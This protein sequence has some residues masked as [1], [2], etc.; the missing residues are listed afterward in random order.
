M[1]YYSRLRLSNTW[2]VHTNF[3]K[4]GT[5]VKP[6]PKAAQLLTN[7]TYFLVVD[8]GGNLFGLKAA[9]LVIVSRN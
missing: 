1:E 9:Y 2:A 6:A 3:E 7:A 5:S 8:F 4:G